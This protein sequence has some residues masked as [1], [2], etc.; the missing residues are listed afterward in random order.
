MKLASQLNDIIDSLYSCSLYNIHIT[1][2]SYINFKMS[3]WIKVVIVWLE[4]CGPNHWR[5]K[6]TTIYINLASMLAVCF[7][8]IWLFAFRNCSKDAPIRTQTI[9]YLYTYRERFI[10]L[11][12]KFTIYIVSSARILYTQHYYSISRNHRAKKNGARKKCSLVSTTDN[13]ILFALL[14]LLS[15]SIAWHRNIE[16]N[17]IYEME[18]LSFIVI[19]ISKWCGRFRM[20]VFSFSLFK[21]REFH[22]FI[23]AFGSVAVVDIAIGWQLYHFHLLQFVALGFLNIMSQ[24]NDDAI[25]A[26]KFNNI[27]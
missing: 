12:A 13:T 22:C 20:N 15:L 17:T 5:S 27:W 7:P 16:I 3:Q 18:S 11:W 4:F 10:Q 6:C 1:V 24:R 8:S 2:Q 23:Q 19:S 14:F 25:L 21:R 9:I 26:N